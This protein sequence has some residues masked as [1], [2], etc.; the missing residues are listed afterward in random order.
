M[1]LLFAEAN[2]S[3]ASKWVVSW[4]VKKLKSFVI[5][6]TFKHLNI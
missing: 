2:I 5:N 3:L 4:K 1:L 6:K